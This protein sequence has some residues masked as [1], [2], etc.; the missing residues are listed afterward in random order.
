M[1]VAVAGII[2]ETLSSLD[3][4]YPKVEVSERKH[5]DELRKELQKQCRLDDKKD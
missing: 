5:F 1:R 4:H 2:Q 3:M